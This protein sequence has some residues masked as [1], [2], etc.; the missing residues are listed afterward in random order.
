MVVKVMVVVMVMG[1][2]MVVVVS[3]GMVVVGWGVVVHSAVFALLTKYFAVAR[4]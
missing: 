4:L 3:V 1:M 2:L